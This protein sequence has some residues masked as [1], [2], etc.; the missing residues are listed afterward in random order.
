PELVPDAAGELGELR[1]RAPQ[2]RHEAVR[3]EDR[4]H[5]V[6]DGPRRPEDR[7]ARLPLAARARLPTIDGL[8]ARDAERSQKTRIGRQ[9]H[10][11]EERLDAVGDVLDPRAVPDASRSRRFGRDAEAVHVA[12]LPLEP[13]MDR[14]IAHAG[15]GYRCDARVWVG[16]VTERR[17]ERRPREPENGHLREED[18]GAGRNFLIAAF[19][20]DS[21]ITPDPSFE[22]ELMG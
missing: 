8:R 4:R 17:V 12:G 16:D 6:F 21:E 18:F 9:E 19:R 1:N 15:G 11:A 22:R 7:R 13:R 2:R 10:T 20:L 3:V 5:P 14:E